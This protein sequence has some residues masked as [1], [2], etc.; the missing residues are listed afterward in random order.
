MRSYL[1]GGWSILEGESSAKTRAHC[2]PFPGPLPALALVIRQ[3]QPCLQASEATVCQ[4]GVTQCPLPSH[5]LALPGVPPP[6]LL[7]GP[8]EGKAPGSQPGDLTLGAFQPASV[9]C[10]KVT[11]K[12][13]TR[14][15]GFEQPWFEALTGLGSMNAHGTPEEDTTVITLTARMWS[16][17]PRPP[18]S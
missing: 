6:K 7:Q 13:A 18:S 17:C 4:Q 9:R 10:L 15:L 2:P 12:T 1:S 11:I 8:A 14:V 16:P 5:E 3:G